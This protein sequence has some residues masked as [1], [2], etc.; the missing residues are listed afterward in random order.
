MN[1]KT[2]PSSE[3]MKLFTTA[4]EKFHLTG[5]CS[6]QCN[7]CHSVIKFEKK[8]TAILHKC[9]CGKFNGSLKGL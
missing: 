5:I 1:T 4:M 3:D 9:D 2:P 6:V 7:V 8:N